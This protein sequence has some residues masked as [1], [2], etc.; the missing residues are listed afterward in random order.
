MLVESTLKI[1]VTPT[2]R[3][4][5]LSYLI[6]YSGNSKM[7]GEMKRAYIAFTLSVRVRGSANNK[8][9]YGTVSVELK[10]LVNGWFTKTNVYKPLILIPC[11]LRS[12]GKTFSFLK[13]QLEWNGITCKMYFHNC[14][15]LLNEAVD[16]QLSK[17]F[18]MYSHALWCDLIIWYASRGYSVTYKGKIITFFTNF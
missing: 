4:V 15:V 10:N 13:R 5:V 8:Q 12:S 1:K 16:L 18:V 6:K 7:Y 3:V 17:F 14:A 2:C 11:P 9:L